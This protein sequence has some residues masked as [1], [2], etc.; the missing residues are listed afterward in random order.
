MGISPSIWKRVKEESFIS[1][2]GKLL[3]LV[4]VWGLVFLIVLERTGAGIDW[5]LNRFPIL[6]VVDVSPVGLYII[7]LVSLWLAF[8]IGK[9]VGMKKGAIRERKRLGIPL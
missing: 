9:R 4:L 8:K 3:S 5:I 6:K 1:I 7:W 2:L